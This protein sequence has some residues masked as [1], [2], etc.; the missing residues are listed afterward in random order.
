MSADDNEELRRELHAMRALLSPRMPSGT[1]WLRLQ[2]LEESATVWQQGCLRV[3]SAVVCLVHADRTLDPRWQLTVIVTGD[4][5][6]PS[7]V[8]MQRVRRAFGMMD[9]AEEPRPG[10]ARHLYLR[11][12]RTDRTDQPRVHSA[13]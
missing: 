13:G 1:P 9:A 4:A 12:S 2:S 8:E 6:R 3:V 10:N 7:A 5:R 11:V